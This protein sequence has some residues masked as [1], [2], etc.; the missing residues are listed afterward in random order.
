M[1]MPAQISYNKLLALYFALMAAKKGTTRVVIPNE[2]LKRYFIGSRKGER[3]SEKR[4]TNFADTLKPVFPKSDVKRD[5]RGPRLVLYLN[6]QPDQ[7]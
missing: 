1:K 3:L 7:A 2:R 4:L 6:E 5:Q